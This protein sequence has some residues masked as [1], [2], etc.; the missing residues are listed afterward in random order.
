MKE[1]YKMAKT[2]DLEKYK[3]MYIQFVETR[4]NALLSFNDTDGKPFSSIAPFVKRDGKLYIYI[5][6]V[7]EHYQ[8][9]ES[10]EYV[11]I[12]L[13]GD[14]ATTK[15]KFAT[16]RVRWI[17]TTKNIG[18]EGHDDIFTLFNEAYGEKLLNVLRGL[19]FSLFELTPAEGRY[20]VGFGLAFTVDIHGDHF[21]HV[22]VDKKKEGEK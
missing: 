19:D 6:E 4:E 18:N 20:V 12:L 21:Q 14:E 22:V 15:N 8:L 3:E 5:S 13:V 11:D 1:G 16:E 7:A 10:N 9:M 2:I 17:C